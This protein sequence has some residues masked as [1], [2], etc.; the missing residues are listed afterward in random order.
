MN[1]WWVICGRPKKKSLSIGIRYSKIPFVALTL[2]SA[3]SKRDPLSAFESVNSRFERLLADQ[4]IGGGC[5]IR[6]I[7]GASKSCPQVRTA[8]WFNRSNLKYV[9]KQPRDSIVI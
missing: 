1:R 3:C 6:I 7:F 9:P 2:P 4:G 5:S 8:A